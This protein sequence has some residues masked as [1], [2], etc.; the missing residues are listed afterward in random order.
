MAR[1]F[2][3]LADSPVEPNGLLGMVLVIGLIGVAAVALVGTLLLVAGRR[4]HDPEEPAAQ[5]ADAAP[6]ATATDDLLARRTLQRAHVRLA[7]DPILSALGVEEQMQARR[8]R[9]ARRVA[10]DDRPNRDA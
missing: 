5:A 10:T 2:V 6:D 4:R 7:D 1:G 9:R 3:A 8:N